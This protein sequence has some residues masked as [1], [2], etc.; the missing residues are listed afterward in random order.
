MDI[1]Y[2][3]LLYIQNSF[4]LHISDKLF[5][6]LSQ[7]IFNKWLN[8]DNN[9]LNFITKLDNNNKQLLLKWGKYNYLL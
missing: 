7:H 1:S 8:S 2:N 5:G 3:I 6:D 4:N 9:I